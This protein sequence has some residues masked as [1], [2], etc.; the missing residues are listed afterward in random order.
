MSRARALALVAGSVFVLLAASGVVLR[1]RAKGEWRAVLARVDGIRAEHER[2]PG[3]RDVLRGTPL[4]GSAFAHYDRAIA[5]GRELGWGNDLGWGRDLRPSRMA[6]PT[7]E[8]RAAREALAESAAPILA[9]LALGARSVDPRMPARWDGEEPPKVH[10]IEATFLG[11]LALALVLRAL[12]GGRPDEAT[13]LL[14]DGLQYA[15]DLI[16]APYLFEA[17][18]GAEVLVSSELLAFGRQG[19]WSRLPAEA[20]TR[21]EEALARID[22]ELA[23]ISDNLEVHEALSLREFELACADEEEALDS[24]LLRAL[25][26]GVTPFVQA[27]AAAETELLLTFAQDYRAAAEESPKK[28]LERTERSYR[29]RTDDERERFLLGLQVES[30]SL[31]LRALARLRLLRH[32]L[33]VHA[34]REGEPAE[35]RLGYRIRAE[36]VDGELRV[37]VEAPCTTGLELAMPTN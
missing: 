8:E 20:L 6:A 7:D 13:D 33:A 30:A 37:R 16:D 29:S 26:V 3:T 17:R 5:L 23:T 2:R 12:D 27:Q 11:D 24:P 18:N 22:A 32:A 36:V 14:L 1:E 19:G 31:R 15:R 25:L 10:R 28:A 21:V 35:D 9:E 4:D 34:G